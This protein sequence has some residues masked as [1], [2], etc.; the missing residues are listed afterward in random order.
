M[1]ANE[2]LYVDEGSE[3]RWQVPREFLHFSLSQREGQGQPLISPGLNLPSVVPDT[4]FFSVFVIV[5]VQPLS[6]VVG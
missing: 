5:A 1:C 6:F 3:E 2:G 4:S